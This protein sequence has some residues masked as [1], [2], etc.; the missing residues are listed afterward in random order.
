MKIVEVITFLSSGGAERF[1][2]DLSNELSKTNEVD[3]LT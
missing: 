3:S 1:M 2:V